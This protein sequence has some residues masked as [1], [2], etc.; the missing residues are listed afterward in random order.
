MTGEWEKEEWYL[1]YQGQNVYCLSISFQLC[2]L[3]TRL[4]ILRVCLSVCM[5]E[6]MSICL[7]VYRVLC[8]QAFVY[9]FWQTHSPTNFFEMLVKRVCLSAGRGRK[10]IS[11][12][13]CQINISYFKSS[14]L[15][16]AVILSEY[17]L[18][19]VW[20]Y[21]A[22]SSSF[23]CLYPFSQMKGNWKQRLQ[24]VRQLDSCF[25][26]STHPLSHMLIAI[27][28]SSIS[29]L[30]FTCSFMFFFFLLW[31]AVLYEIRLSDIHCNVFFSFKIQKAFI[32]PSLFLLFI[33]YLSLL[34][35]LSFRLS[36]RLFI[37]FNHSL[38]RH[39]S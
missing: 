4:V 23:V 38:P 37:F 32:I 7:L 3:H 10:S 16:A 34:L 20:W 11:I 6:C 31:H 2:T 29:H 15:W 9:F 5:Y 21:P 17:C 28:S 22:Q 33:C 39:P 36:L 24:L 18:A 35:H 12:C 27:L 14:R 1:L 8:I 13:S 19:P 26:S 25:V 30:P